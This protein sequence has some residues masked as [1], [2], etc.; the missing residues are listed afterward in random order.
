VVN[1]ACHR[2]RY[3][4]GVERDRA[5]AERRVATRRRKH[6][7]HPIENAL[8]GSGGMIALTDR[9]LQILMLAA[10]AIDIKRRGIFSAT[11]RAYVEIALSLFR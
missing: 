1:A 2:G 7:L 3:L 6:R 4:H 10:A 5:E 8:S 11:L 9:Q